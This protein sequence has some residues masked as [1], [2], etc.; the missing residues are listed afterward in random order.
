MNYNSTKYKI[1]D[2]AAACFSQNG[3]H[4]TTV[5]EMFYG[6]NSSSYYCLLLLLNGVRISEFR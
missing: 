6:I 1:I 2:A 4:K 3:F 5:D